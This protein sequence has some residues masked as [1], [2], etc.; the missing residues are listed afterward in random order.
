MLNL[1]LDKTIKSF[2]RYLFSVTVLVVTTLISF[3]QSNTLDKNIMIGGF[4]KAVFYSNEFNLLGVS[5]AKDSIQNLV[6]KS[7]QGDLQNVDSGIVNGFLSLTN[8]KNGKV[9]ISVFSKVDTGLHFLNYKTFSVITKPLSSDEKKVMQLK[10]KPIFSLEGY[11]S[12]K[13]PIDIAKAATKFTINKPYKVKSI[14]AYFGSSKGFSNP[15]AVTLNSE[16]FDQNFIRIWKRIGIGTLLNLEIIE[17]VDNK[18]NTY[19]L[20]PQRFMIAE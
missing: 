17:I 4:Q 12:G 13:V 11:V 18:G 10:V 15:I 16:L 8:L 9:T 7:S 1:H 3:C 5:S 20:K 19:K 2:I 6:I 14:L